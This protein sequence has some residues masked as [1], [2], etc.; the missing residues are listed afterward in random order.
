MTPQEIKKTIEAFVDYVML[1]GDKSDQDLL[2][3]IDRIM[4]ARQHIE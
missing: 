4:V 1:D 2:A 3:I